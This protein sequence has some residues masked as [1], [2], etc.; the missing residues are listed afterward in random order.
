M[1][2]FNT[3]FAAIHRFLAAAMRAKLPG[4]DLSKLEG[5]TPVWDPPATGWHG[6]NKGF[7][8]WRLRRS[9]YMPHQGDRERHRR[10]DQMMRGL[11]PADQLAV[12]TYRP[13]RKPAQQYIVGYVPRSGV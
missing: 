11:V 5:P 9:K 4:I 6:H 12:L 1:G 13:G 10:Y 7:N 3:M 2:A 8:L